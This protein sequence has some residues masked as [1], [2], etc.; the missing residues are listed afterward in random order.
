MEESVPEL[1]KHPHISEALRGGVARPLGG[2]AEIVQYS[3]V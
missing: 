1:V 2:H 3:R